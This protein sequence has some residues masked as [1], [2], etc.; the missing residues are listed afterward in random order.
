MAMNREG[1]VKRE[2]EAKREGGFSTWL[3][4]VRRSGEYSDVTVRVEGED[5]HVHLLPLLNASAYFRNVTSHPHW[6]SGW[7]SDASHQGSRVISLPNLPGGAEGFAGA[8]D[9]CYLIKP[10]YT[11]QNVARIRAAA[12]YLG[13]NDVLESTKKFLYQN[14]F[15]HWRPSVGC[16][17]QYHPVGSPVDEYIE[18]RCLKVLVAAL[19][20]AFGET[21]H[22]SAPMP[23]RAGNLQTSPCQV[24]SEILVRTAS[25]PDAYAA[26]ALDA[27]VEADV[28]LN[29][30]CRQGRTVRSWLDSVID[31]QCTTDRARCSVVLCLARML[32]RGAPVCRPWL[33]L[34]SQYWCSLL[35]HVDHLVSLVGDDEDMQEKL[36][37]VK[38]VIERRVGVSL[39]ELDDYLHSYKLGPDTL[40]AMVGYWLDEG[41]PDPASFEEIAGE[42]DGFLWTYAEAG[43]IDPE[44]FVALFKAFPNSSRQSH[45]TIFGAVEKLLA[46]RPD[47]SPEEKQSLWRLIDPAKLSPAVNERAL[48]NPGFLSQPH[49]LEIVLQKH[50]E[51]LAKMP[52]TDAQNMRHIMQKVINASLKLLE[53]NSRRSQEIME[54]QQQYSAL[55][56]GKICHLQDSCDNSP[57]PCWRP[58]LTI[59]HR[60]TQSETEGSEYSETPSLATVSS[61][62]PRLNLRDI[63]SLGT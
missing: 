37:D 13:M 19:A 56:G 26:E 5:F 36:L 46:T 52:D 34:S 28:N 41:H 4:Q 51:E 21:K 33:E 40:M 43:A 45:D 20:R 6:S 14:I 2:S 60:T 58:S 42:V 59:T 22:L 55:M 27:L 24:L 15:A 17:L 23:L 38:R 10:N 49:I 7:S 18:T 32:L 9:Y 12:E 63:Y 3:Q 8:V 35:E 47:A 54:L 29:L 50:S 62:E 11:I 16:L 31:D 44:T 39:D 30:K 57:S 1:V 48:N 61:I 53:E 25:L